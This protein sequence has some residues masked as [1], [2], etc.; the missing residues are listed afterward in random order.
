M[1][2]AVVFVILVMFVISFCAAQSLNDAQKNYDI[3]YYAI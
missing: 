2:K 3:I 1:K